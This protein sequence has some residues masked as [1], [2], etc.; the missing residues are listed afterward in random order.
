MLV[1]EVMSRDV[2]SVGPEATLKEAVRLLAER[3]VTA[4]PVVDGS[5]RLLGVVSEADVLRERLMPDV[6]LHDLPVHAEPPPAPLR[7]SDVM[8][9][10]P[11]T[12][13]PGTDLEEATGLLTDTEVKSLPVLEHGRVVGMVSRADVVAVLARS[14]AL[15]EAEVD[16]LLR[17]ADLE[18]EVVVTDGV[19]ELDGPDEPHQRE[20]ARVLAG[21]VAG[22][23]G[24]GFRR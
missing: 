7:V 18:V 3:R 2:V 14:D 20:M 12:V 9:H 13:E 5:G 19:V 23:V 16:D 10:F 22:V 4:M 24:V 1:R 8:S 6:R 15:I 21:T 11:L 17:G